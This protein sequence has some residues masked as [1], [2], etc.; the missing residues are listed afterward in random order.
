MA[1]RG[2]TGAAVPEGVRENLEER[3]HRHL[4]RHWKGRWVAQVKY[5]GRYVYLSARPTRG[6]DSSDEFQLCRLEWRGSPEA[7]G[8]AF[9]KYS[10]GRYEPSVLM[11]GS[12]AGP[13]EAALDC[14]GLVYLR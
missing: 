3:L 11:D 5:K 1:R 4:T 13:P 6:G 7:W 8:F 14:A 9:F 10:D 12:W 2:H